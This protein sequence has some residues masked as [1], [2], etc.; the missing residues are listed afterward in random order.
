MGR[1]Q[2]PDFIELLVPSRDRNGKALTSVK[3]REWRERLA[4]FLLE[5]LEVTGFQESKR[6]GVWKQEQKNLLEYDP[7]TE[8]LFLVHE[9]VHVMRASC[10]RAQVTAFRREGEA[11]LVE[12]GKALNQEAVA[13]ETREGLTIL[14]L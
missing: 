4:R 11:L 7:S 10:T 3:Q 1:T 12:M 2:L 13:Y 14:S 5:S 8:R 6:M 9:K